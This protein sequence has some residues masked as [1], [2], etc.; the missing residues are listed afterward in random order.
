MT[1]LVSKIF[2]RL[3][4]QSQYMSSSTTSNLPAASQTSNLESQ[5]LSSAPPPA[6]KKRGSALLW[7]LVGFTTYGLGETYKFLQTQVYKEHLDSRKQCLEMKPM[8]LN[9]TKDLDGLGFR[10]VVCKG[11]FDEQRSIYVGPKPRSM[12]KSS[13]IGFYVITPLLPIPNE[14]NSMKSPILVNRGWVPS[15]W[16]E[17]SL[18]SLGTGGLVAA[19]KESR[20][21]NKLLSSQQSLLSKF[22]YKLNNPMIVEQDQV[23]RAMHV[24]V[25]GVVR[26]SETPGIYTLVNY[27]SSLAWFYLDVPKLALAMGFGEDTMYIESTY[28]DMDESR[29]Y[30]V[31]RDVENLTRSK[32]IPLDYHLYTVL[33]HWS[34][35]TCFIKASSILMRRLTKSDPIGVEPILIP[36]SILV[37]ICTKIYSL[38]NLFCKIDTIGVG[39]VTKLDT[40]KVK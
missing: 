14:P 35:L 7:Y 16:K 8:K 24:E 6:K 15:D 3:I 28:T 5:L 32:D 27:P 4:S 20:K 29:T 40:G 22:W 33:W 38:R 23:S 25:V 19:A 10:R 30:P 17:N 37:F 2:K 18:E 13:E 12:S 31:P 34:S 9:T 36:I 26:K 1:K 21:A 11:I 39:C